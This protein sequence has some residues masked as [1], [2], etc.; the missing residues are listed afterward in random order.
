MKPRA[1]SL[2][3]PWARHAARYSAPDRLVI[4]LA[5]GEVPASIPAAVDVRSGAQPAAQKIDGGPVD[6]ILRELG[7]GFRASR[8]HAAAASLG[9]KGQ[10]HRRF[11]DLEH[12]TGLSRTLSIELAEEAYITGLVEMLS[13]V[14]KVEQV[15]PY[16]LCSVPMDAPGATLPFSAEE[17]EWSREQ[18]LADQALGYEPGDPAVIVAIVDT[19]VARQHGEL[20]RLRAGFDTVQLGERDLARGVTLLG[21]RSTEDADPDDEVGHGTGCAGIVGASGRSI[22]AGL[23]GDS[24]LLP[25]RVLGAAS[26]PGKDQPIGI[27]ALPDIDAGIKMAVDLGARVLNLSLGTPGSSLA[28]DDPLP[29]ADAVSYALMRGCIVIAAS[30][31]SGAEEAYY[32]AAL[33]GVIAVGAVDERDEP[34]PFSTRGAHV[35]LC[36]P[37]VRVASTGIGGYQLVTGT[38]FAAPFVAATAA[39]IVS[40]ALRRSCPVDAAI[41]RELLMGSARPFAPRRGAGSGAGVLDAH[42]ALCALDRLIDSR[43]SAESFS[44]R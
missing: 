26:V 44:A 19:G 5:A 1:F 43:A 8:V 11:D 41:V 18:V 7:G 24:G 2:A 16:Y 31:N 12:V 39:L 33:D 15:S 6:R 30:G 17:A 35:A 42:A 14:A 4:K 13:G 28:D 32:P 40:R 23:G 34:A 37:G 9:V 29:H 25:I 20:P 3:M 21:D 27:G 36:A 38:S 10:G 22:P